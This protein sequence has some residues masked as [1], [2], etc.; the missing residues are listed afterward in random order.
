MSITRQHIGRRLNDRVTK[1]VIEQLIFAL[2]SRVD[3]HEGEPCP[4]C[5]L[6]DA[7]SEVLEP[8]DYDKTQLPEKVTAALQ[9]VAKQGWDIENA[10]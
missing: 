8:Y 5:Q 4:L 2:N 10:K 3:W 7:V 9:A 6:C 1:K